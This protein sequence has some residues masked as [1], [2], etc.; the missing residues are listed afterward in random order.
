M[1][2]Y[3][4]D[5]LAAELG[6]P[7]N[8][9]NVLAVIENL[10]PDP[11]LDAWHANIRKCRE[12]ARWYWDMPCALNQIARNLS[13][14]RY[15]EIGV[16]RGKSMAMIASIC[17]NISISAF[18]LWLTPYGG[19][20]NPGPD[21]VRTELNRLGFRGGLHF[22]NGDSKDT[23]PAFAGENP[24]LRFGAVVVDG[25]HSDEG[26]WRDLVATAPLVAPGGFLLFDDLINP[27]H[28][29]LPVWR[30]FQHEYRN[31]FCFIENIADHNGAGV[32]QR[33]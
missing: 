2:T 5:R 14:E 28:T 11:T 7:A 27:A 12:D 1:T 4:L 26:A 9:S 10:S 20:D 33:C 24:T 3:P 25:D 32:A 19:V 15:L 6:T 21:Y 30:R 29:L 8:L 16:R 22:H 23:V 13:P 17:P 31:E 18:D